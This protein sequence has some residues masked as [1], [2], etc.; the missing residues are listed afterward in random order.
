LRG[1]STRDYHDA[2]W[3][4]LAQSLGFANEREMWE[5]I[6]PTIWTK[7]LAALTG[8]CE[9]TLVKRIR[10]F[11]IQMRG[12]GGP[13]KH[14]SRLPQM[15]AEHGFESEAEMYQT[16]LLMGYSRKR[17]AM[18]LGMNASYIGQRIWALGVK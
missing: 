8:Y 17:I 18:K 15:A 13:H 5:T 14:P 3:D 11:G 10:R 12:R 1:Q 2:K 6:Y 4:E 7:E 16:W 9:A